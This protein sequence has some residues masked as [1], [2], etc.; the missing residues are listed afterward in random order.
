MRKEKNIRNI[1][2]LAHVD[3]GK[4]T[5]TENMLF[6]SGVIRSLGAVDKGTTRTDNLDI[7]RQRGISV[8]AS[9]V[10]FIWRDTEINL[11]DTP[12]HAD[13]SAEVE[14]ALGVLDGAV[15][16]ISAVEGVQP[17]TK[18]YFDAL[19]A[20]KIPTLIV[21]NKIDRIGADIDRVIKDIN[22]QLTEKVAPIQCIEGE[23][24]K[25]PV[26]KGISTTDFKDSVYMEEAITKL[27]E[28]DESLLEAYLEDE[29]I[30]DNRITE[31]LAKITGQGDFYP[32]LFASGIR[33]VGIE[34]LMDSVVKLFPPLVVD[35][36]GDLSAIVYK[37]EHHKV[38]GKIAYV[39]MFQGSLENRTLVHNVT[40][41][42]E[43]KVAQIKKISGYKEVDCT[44]LSAGDIGIIS[45]LSKISIGDILGSE[46]NIPFVPNIAKPL[47]TLQI[48][49]KQKGKYMELVQAVEIL[50]EED[51]LLNFQW[52]KEK[53]ELHIQIMGMIQV[54]I[55][56]AILLE[57]FN[58]VVEFG[59]PSVIYKET[60][61]SSGYGHC[62][63]TMPKPCWAVTR[64]KIEPAE[65]GSG[66]SYKSEVRKDD[67]KE[68]YQREVERQLPI[69]LK[70]GIYGWEVIDLKVTLV[71]GEDHVMNSNP[72]DF[73]IA[74]AM[75][76]MNGL[77]TVKTTLL[78][79]VLNFKIIVPEEVGGKLLGDIVEMRGTFDTPIIEAGT[80]NV[81]GQLPVATS[82]DY[83]VKLGII[84]SGKGIMITRFS[85][86]KP[87]PLELGATRE[88][89]GVN[90]LDREKYIL[91]SRNAI[92]L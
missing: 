53:N 1:G 11:I 56:E 2:I 46:E 57:R 8:K 63:Y 37:V 84:S 30:G 24:T 90:P 14:R 45:G 10:N 51:P 86:Y 66:L 61:A 12:G 70:Q 9:A 48:F 79:P 72:G 68:K 32:I 59:E 44:K 36:E 91:F 80:F 47:L 89:V 87:I 58:I 20:M 33:N 85:G 71:E 82:L 74:T 50:E 69:T 42:V 29:E 43:E 18:V 19:K 52:I 26:I 3:A 88:R 49:P 13:F 73:L 31:A 54:E 75:G 55:L 21:I 40:K 76:I 81:E 77:A 5:I 67:I 65:T 25:D 4:T 60:P 17:Q 39:R 35:E 6:K 34:E 27:S 62:R 83:P 28:Y 22:M 15:L 38:L 41:D 23:N 78:E 16:I 7:E 64:F 92:R